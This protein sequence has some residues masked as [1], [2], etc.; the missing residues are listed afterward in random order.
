MFDDLDDLLD[1]IPVNKSKPVSKAPATTLSKAKSAFPSTKKK[2]EDDE[3]DWGGGGGVSSQ[4][5][6][7]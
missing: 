6:F 2:D 1:D 7:G 5:S 4:M 3:F